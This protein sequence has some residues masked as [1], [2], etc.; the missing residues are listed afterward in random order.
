MPPNARRL[1]F[2]VLHFVHIYMHN[3][4]LKLIQGLLPIKRSLYYRRYLF[5][6]L[7]LYVTYRR[8]VMNPS[9]HR[10]HFAIRRFVRAYTRNS[11]TTGCM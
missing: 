1:G 7:E 4:K 5:S 3:S 2:L 8:R 9:T 11:K 6:W 10:N